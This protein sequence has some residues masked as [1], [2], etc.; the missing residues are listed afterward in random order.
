[1]IE[2]LAR[3]FLKMAS[4]EDKRDL[5][6]WHGKRSMLEHYPKTGI[7]ETLT[8]QTMYLGLLINTFLS[9]VGHVGLMEPP[10][11]SLID[12]ISCL[13]ITILLPLLLVLKLWLIAKLEEIVMEVTLQAYMIMHITMEFL[14][15]HACSMSRRILT[16]ITANL[17]MFA[18]IVM[19]LL[20]LKVM[21]DL[22]TVLL[23]PTIN[24][25]THQ[26]TTD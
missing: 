26:T 15:P 8:A 21:T 9:T 24:V 16:K 20:L 1:M 17:L 14:I 7:G 5:K 10:Q 13:K 22:R 11:P 19:D 6:K 23:L 25:T 3:E 18:E 12:S 2:R 4:R